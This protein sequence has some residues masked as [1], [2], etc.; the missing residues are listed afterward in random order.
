MRVLDDNSRGAPRRLTEVERD[1]E[2]IA[3]DVR[4]ATAVSEATRGMD[5][6]M[7]LAYVNGTEFF[8]SKPKLVLEVGVKGA[9]HTLDAAIACGVR[10]YYLMSSSEVYQSPQK[11]PTDETAPFVVPDPLKPRYSY[12]GGKIISELLAINY[13]RECFDR[14]VIVRPHN[15]Y[16]PDMGFEHVIPTHQGRAAEKILFSV[17]G[18]PGKVIPNNTHFDTTRANVESTGASAVD[19]FVKVANSL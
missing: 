11:V 19:S 1:I 4:D 16:G 8:Y 10:E 14:M 6:V 13:A 18:G 5:E 2:F 15:V 12:A 9:I 3:G 7:H 17:V